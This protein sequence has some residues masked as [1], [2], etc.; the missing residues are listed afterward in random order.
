M[1]SSLGAS[2]SMTRY[3]LA[4]RTS[5]NGEATV[6][7]YAKNIKLTTTVQ[8]LEPSKIL[9]PLLEILYEEVLVADLFQ[10]GVDELGNPH[11]SATNV[12]L[13]FQVEY[14][15]NYEGFWRS[16][17]AFFGITMTM[18]GLV[19]LLRLYNW[20]RRNSQLPGDGQIDLAF[21][22]RGISY[23]LST[24]S[25]VFFWFLFCYAAY[26][27]VFFK[28]QDNVHLLLPTNR[29]EYGSYND[30]YPFVIT[31]QVCFFGQVARMLEIVVRQSNVDVFFL[32]WEKPRGRI[33]SKRGDGTKSRF[34]P[35]S[36]WR[37][38][39]MV[40]EYAEMQT[41]RR[42]SVELAL[43][44][45]ATLLIGADLQFA[46]TPT[47]NFRDLTPG[48]LN[49]VLRFFNTSFWFLLIVYGEI[50]WK[51]AIQDRYF[52]EPPTHAFVDLATMA[53]TSVFILDEKYHG[54]YLHCRSQHEYADV[55][56]LEI[57]RQLQQEQQGLTTDRGLPGC[58]SKSLQTF[59]IY[60]TGEWKR[61]YNHIFRSMMTEELAGTGELD[62]FSKLFRRKGKP[63]SE[64]LVKAS[65][66]L[67]AFL[68]GFVDQDTSNFPV[69]HRE[70]TFLHRFLHTPPEMLNN[71]D[72]IFFPD[73]F[74]NYDKVLFYGETWNLILFNLLCVTTFDLWW[75][76]TMLAIFATF[77]F[78]KFFV[79]MRTITGNANLSNKTLVDDRFMI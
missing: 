10:A 32:D 57:S 36:I 21:I 58:P 69:S 79:I 62:F 28:M 55:S 6:I 74:Y 42:Y 47:P 12:E 67:N 63:S 8:D 68:R 33:P 39:F 50:I 4:P 76:N 38:L 17:A 56:M 34:A 60:V 41:Y 2:S 29:E 7:R 66:K 3:L 61:Q 31:L 37:T 23:M 16:T 35:I 77:L 44:L 26:F 59:E 5:L 46:A 53:K 30:Y 64:R 19:G 52:T 49:I 71:K 75:D 1:T 20:S 78:D 40:N 70:Q 22:A 27:F 11:S 65:R 9:P 13:T 25:S 24:F 45:T 73:T 51:W 43:I 48:T 14:T 18:V 72:S 15:E 54:Y